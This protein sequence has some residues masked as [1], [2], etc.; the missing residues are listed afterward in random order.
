L[1][2]LREEREEAG[3]EWRAKAYRKAIV[4]IEGYGKPIKSAE[5]AQRIPGVGARIAGRIKEILSTG[6]LKEI[7]LDLD[8]TR[9]LELFKSI[10]QVGSKT[11]L[12]WYLKGYRTLADL[13][14]AELTDAQ[15]IGLKYREELSERIPRHEIQRFE[16]RLKS[17]W[18]GVTFEICGSY[19]RGKP[20]SGDID[21]LICGSPRASLLLEELV[22]KSECFTDTLA[23]GHQK[24]LGVGRIDK[25]HRR[26]DLQ[27]TDPREYPFALLHFTGP[28]GL[29]VQMRAHA[30]KYGYRLNEKNL[31]RISTG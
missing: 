26:I 21:V 27:V 19:R 22:S 25:L 31:A 12:K 15:R 3:E 10:F 29:N 17:D 2:R 14:V 5:E 7:K 6:Q 28:G 9:V 11:A 13:P 30:A 8:K 1:N 20:D 23:L 16:E 24:Y 18:P 4:G